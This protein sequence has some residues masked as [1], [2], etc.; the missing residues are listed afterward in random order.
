MAVVDWPAVRWPRGGRMPAWTR[1]LCLSRK[2]VDLRDKHVIALYE[3][4][5]QINRPLPD[6]TKPS[7]ML[8]RLLEVR[9]Y[10]TRQLKVGEAPRRKQTKPISPTRVRKIHAVLLSALN[11]AVKSK[12]LRENPIAHVETPRVRGRRAKPLV[13]TAERVQRWQET[14]KVPG[15]VMVWT[16]AQTG[17]FLDFIADERLYA[18]FHL[19][20]FRGLRRAEVAGL[21]GRTPT[22]RAQGR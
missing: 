6:G 17:A 21:A 11:W 19:V 7:E 8:R 1:L 2:L 20:A 16:P 15:P 3:A 14:G 12:R 5:M 18:L 4:I 22:S 10:S 9:A 13:W